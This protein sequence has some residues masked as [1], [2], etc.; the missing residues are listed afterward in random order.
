MAH[1]GLDLQGAADRV[2]DMW[3]QAVEGFC[4]NK[5]KVPSWGPKIDEDV[6]KYIQGLED[7]IVG[8]VEWSFSSERYFGKEGPSIKQTRLVT[9]MEKRVPRNAS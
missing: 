1:H 7:W 5:M 2:G 8:G 4:T 3:R 9:L 6:A